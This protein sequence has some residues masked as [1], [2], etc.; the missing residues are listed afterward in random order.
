MYIYIYIYLN[1]FIS[2]SIK[3]DNWS[4]VAKAAPY[5]TRSSQEPLYIFARHPAR[6]TFC[7][8]TNAII[9]ISS[10]VYFF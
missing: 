3:R 4:T 6:L 2:T 7:S 8:A 5:V 10:C 9:I 1:V